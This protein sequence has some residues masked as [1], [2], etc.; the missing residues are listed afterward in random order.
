MAHRVLLA[1]PDGQI[2]TRSAYPAL[3]TA[4]FS[5]LAVL[6]SA[7]KLQDAAA[8]ADVDAIVVEAHLAGSP[9][10]SVRMLAELGDVPIVV[11]LPPAWSAERERFSELPHLVAGFGSPVSWPNVAVELV[12]RL[13][14]RGHGEE[15][16]PEAKSPDVA[17][18]APPRGKSRALEPEPSATRGSSRPGR[19]VRLGFYGTRG[20]AGTSTTALRV[21]TLLAASGRH[22]GLFDSRARGDVLLLMGVPPE[23]IDEARASGQAVAQERIALYLMPPN[24]ESAQQYDAIVVDAGRKPGSF[25]ADWVP[26][27]RPL[28]EDQIARLVAAKTGKCRTDAV[29]LGPI[30]I[31]VED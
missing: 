1:G 20:G 9:E 23:L 5:V 16:D 24:E 13:S 19:S 30:S 12:Q 26:V 2:L 31:Q 8:V 21:A 29:T 11:I 22:V 14:P 27:S 17:T 25:N 10:Q 3:A 15:P 18:Q 7:K 6:D 4:G 28:S